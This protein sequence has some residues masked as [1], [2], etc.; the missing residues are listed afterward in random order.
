MYD[1]DLDALAAEYV[2]GTLAADERAHAE[3]L[4][5]VDPGF[6]EIVHLWERRLGELN[7]MVEAVEPPE[8]LWN[9]I[10]KG[11]ST[12]A[13]SDVR[14]A[15]ADPAPPVAH[16]PP[17][18]P[19]QAVNSETEPQSEATAEREA[20]D[21]PEA[22]L[23]PA[24]ESKAADEES[25]LLAALASSLLSAAKPE[26]GAKSPAKPAA[27]FKLQPPAALVPKLER[28]SDVFVLAHRLRRWRTFA[29][30]SGALAAVLAAFVAISQVAPEL[31]PPGSV[32]L[33]VLFAQSPSPAAAA[34]G[35]QFV[36]VLQRD[37]TSPGF[38]LTVDPAR[39][40]LVVRTV[41]AKTAAGHSYELWL[42]SPQSIQPRSLGLVGDSQ[43]AERSLPADI[44]A[45]TMR[46]A[47]YA[48]SFEPTGG[49]KTGTP[50]G[51][52]LFTG[53]L[54]EAVPAAP[55]PKT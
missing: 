31:I 46:S 48:I 53:K 20:E 37:P 3:A 23:E 7:V 8:Q 39:R 17:M 54:L 9:K 10:R 33:P 36:A 11:I 6:G 24:A 42:M 14:L 1:E 43:Y 5:A 38:L 21:S 28:S 29:V 30:L 18:A 12:V 26:E 27:D 16:A 15:P 32:H 13:P 49:S 40:V 2:L 51:P 52:V 45:S 47:T 34:P 35:S 55:P 44:D 22:K 4:I 19:S 50:T 41:A 25:P